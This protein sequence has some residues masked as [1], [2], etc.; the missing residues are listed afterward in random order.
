VC[1][2]LKTTYLSTPKIKPEKAVPK[3]TAFFTDY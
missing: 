3:E 2:L 1:M